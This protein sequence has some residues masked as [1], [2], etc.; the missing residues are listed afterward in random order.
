MKERAM[1]RR[2]FTA[3]SLSAIASG[4]ITPALAQ[5]SAFKEGTDYLPLK[6]RVATD[7][8][9]GKIE[10]LEFF[11]YNCPH[12]NAFEPALSAWSKKLPKDVVLKRVPVRFREDFEPQQRAFYVLEA[13]G[14]VEELQAK[15]FAA[16]HVEKQNLAKLDTLLVWGEKNGIP[17]KQFTDLYNSFAVIGKARQAAKLQEDFKVEG[18]PALGIG[19]RYYVDGSLAGSMERALQ[20]TDFLTSEIRKGR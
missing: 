1:Q 20:I 6:N 5:A 3:L 8:G 4:S 9:K 7:V 18:V 10:V 17:A 12:C 2:E 19:G 13:L 16:I 15:M 14:K 11:W